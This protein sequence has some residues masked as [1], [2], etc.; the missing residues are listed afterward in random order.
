MGV[1]DPEL[2]SRDMWVADHDYVTCRVR[3]CPSNVT[4]ASITTVSLVE[5]L[6]ASKVFLISG[7]FLIK[8]SLNS[9]AMLSLEENLYD[10]KQTFLIV[11]TSPYFV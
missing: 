10:P 6:S 11:P 1:R 5:E 7:V 2:A 3:G 8:K 9:L 4:S